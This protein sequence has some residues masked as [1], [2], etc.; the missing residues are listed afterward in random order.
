MAADNPFKLNS[1]QLDFI[2]LSAKG[3]VLEQSADVILD[4]ASKYDAHVRKPGVGRESR[5]GGLKK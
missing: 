5:V 3:G 4:S 1:S 2:L